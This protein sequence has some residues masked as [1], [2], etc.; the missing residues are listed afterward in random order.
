VPLNDAT[1]SFQR[2]VCTEGVVLFEN[3]PGEA[4]DATVS[5]ISQDIDYREWRRI[6]EQEPPGNPAQ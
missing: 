4:L 2:R 3:A 5:A 6:H 1:P